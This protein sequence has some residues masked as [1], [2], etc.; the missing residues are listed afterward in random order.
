[1]WRGGELG[2]WTDWLPRGVFTDAGPEVVA[3]LPPM[4]EATR[5]TLESVFQAPSLDAILGALRAGAPSALLEWWGTRVASPF[6]K[7]IQFPASIFA[8]RGSQA[9]VETPQVIIGTI[10]SVK[11]GEADVVFLFPDLSRAGEGQYR[12]GGPLRDSVIRQ[13]YVGAT[14]AR[15]T[16][17]LCAPE[18]G[19]AIPI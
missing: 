7:R 9:L 12:R 5:E 14:R 15:E 8:R 6:R 1:M 18:S 19:A 11:G 16:L 10:H 13:F 2:L 3:A 17:Y 4:K